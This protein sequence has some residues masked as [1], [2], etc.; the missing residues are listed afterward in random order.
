MRG[1]STAP[2]GHRRSDFVIGRNGLRRRA[3][4]SVAQSCFLS[5][6]NMRHAAD[7]D[8][9]VVVGVAHECFK[10]EKKFL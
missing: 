4:F 5:N 9:I 10:K 8:R 7:H 1:E 3:G 2:S 6:R